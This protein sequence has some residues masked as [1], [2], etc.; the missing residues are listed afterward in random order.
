MNRIAGTTTKIATPFRGVFLHLYWDKDALVEVGVSHQL[1]D[2]DAPLAQMLD[3]MGEW[4]NLAL[5]A[6]LLPLVTQGLNEAI[7]AGPCAGASD[8][9]AA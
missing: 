4:M 9:A 1:K 5:K 3:A 8:G 2:F 6:G 7:K